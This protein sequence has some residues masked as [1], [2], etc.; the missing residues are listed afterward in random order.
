M[1]SRGAAVRYWARR[2]VASRWRA[3]VVLGL[4]GGLAGGVAFAA[5]AGARRTDSVYDRWRDETLAPDAIVFPTQA[6]IFDADFTAVRALPEVVD[7][8]EFVL[9][10]VEA[11]GLGGTLAPGDDQLYRTVARPLLVDGRLPDPNRPDEVLINREAAKRFDVGDRLIVRVPADPDAFFSGAETEVFEE[12]ATIVGVGEGPMDQIFGNDQPGFVPSWGLFEKYPDVVR[13]T[14]LVVRLRPGTDV[15]AFRERVVEVMGV[16]DMPVRDLAED[17]KR[18]TNGTDLE[19][20]GL[21]LFAAAAFLAGLVLVGQAITRVVYAIAE[22]RPA[23]HAMGMTRG[24][25]VAG[26]V[27]P[28]ALTAVVA[29]A[30]TTILAIALSPLFPI[31]L[32]GTLE[33]DPGLDVDVLVI[34]LGALA[35]FV[36]TLVIAAA[37]GLRATSP[38]RLRVE[39][40][41][42]LVRRIRTVAPLPVAIGAGLALERGRGERSLPVW[43]AIAGA[44]AAV[45]GIVGALGLVAG[46]DDALADRSRSGQ[47]LD[48]EVFAD[49]SIS[50]RAATRV[51]LDASEPEEIV[52]QIRVPLVIGGNGTAGYSLTPVRGDLR[53]EL[54]D[55]REPVAP[56]EIA[57]GPATAKSLDRGVGDRVHVEGDR[58]S[59]RVKVVGITLLPQTA[60]S[61]FDQG[62]W[63]T[64]RGLRS[65]ASTELDEGDVERAIGFTVEPGTDLEALADRLADPLGPTARVEQTALPQDVYQLR[66]VRSLP[67]VLAIFLALLGIAAVGH[68]LVTAVRRRRGDIAILRAVG[69]R[70]VQAAACIGWQATIVGVIG[71]VIGIPLGIV[72]GR[73]AWRWVAD[74]TPLLYA[75]PVAIAGVLLVVPLTIVVTNLLAAL[76]ARRAARIRPATVLRTE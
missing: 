6:A 37:A 18:I 30:S 50:A 3:L 32:A 26:L 57:L 10:Y 15:T 49:E 75:G 66:N 8:G 33:P 71:L 51:V 56:D 21:L 76:P 52:D 69:F 67:R 41:P 22:V 14:N 47:V 5:L 35:V 11:K 45:V 39:R 72:A 74:N 38:A 48:L 40:E 46:I 7:A 19:R 59:A 9:P 12:R 60:H 1:G 44:V 36:V 54:L 13:V 65:V 16:D 24:Q 2:E 58:G 63:M 42:R 31:G 53:Y 23:L 62:G 70:P 28:L 34:G 61:S 55:G 27:A 17:N 43:P 29:A 68:V 64:R 73:L 20:T 4:L 25:L